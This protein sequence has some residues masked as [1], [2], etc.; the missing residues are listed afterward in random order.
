MATIEPEILKATPKELNRTIRDLKNKQQQ[1]KELEVE[2]N[3][4]TSKINDFRNKLEKM[5][6]EVD[7]EENK[8]QKLKEAKLF[9]KWQKLAGIIKG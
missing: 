5:N 6:I 1:A 3:D 9:N 7:L 4:S 2:I 8:K